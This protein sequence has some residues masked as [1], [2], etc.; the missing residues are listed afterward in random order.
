MK[1]RNLKWLFVFAL[2]L[3]TF[4]GVMAVPSMVWV[5]PPI[6]HGT[7]GV[8]D[9]SLVESVL[10]L[11]T[12]NPETQYSN[13]RDWVPCWG[14]NPWS[15]DGQW[16]VYQSGVGDN[17]GGGGNSKLNEICIIR[18]DGSGYKRLTYNMYCDTHGNFT[19]DGKKIVFQRNEGENAAIWIM[20]SDGS[21]QKS[22]TEEHGTIGDSCS[23]DCGE[24]KP[25]VSPDG[26]KIAFRHGSAIYVMNIDGSNPVKVSANLNGPT[27]HSWA[28]DSVWVLFNASK[29][30]SEDE[31]G[32]NIFKVRY[33]GKDLTQLTD[34]GEDFCNNWAAWSPDGKWI[35]YHHGYNSRVYEGPRDKNSLWI[36]QADGSGKRLLV[37]GLNDAV[38]EE[39]EWVCGPHSWHPSA[40]WIVF[41][42]YEDCSNSSL[43]AINIATKNIYRLTEGYGDGRMW[44]SPKGSH[45]LFKEYNTSCGKSRDGKLGINDND[46]DL[47]VLNMDSRFDFKGS[48]TVDTGSIIDD[49]FYANEGVSEESHT[50]KS[51]N[52]YCFIATAAFG[53]PLAKQ[54]QILRNFRD[55]YLLTN[56]AGQKF[57]AWY[58]QNGPVAAAWI[59]DKPLAKAAVQVALYPLIGFSFLL[60]SGYMPAA[61]LGFLLTA[62]FF[63]RFRENKFRAT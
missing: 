44:W 49:Y 42:R 3:L 22:L 20:N 45:I 7:L 1:K 24:Q 39:D 9:K 30:A 59:K 46:Y 29:C 18:P 21:N 25:M 33:N 35:S 26:T 38:D 56:A 17:K 13:V 5:E 58:Y 34:D 57:V 31:C 12:G 47:L 50:K 8:A 55:R 4:T 51:G 54:V 27:K 61:A 52:D 28:P 32:Q 41:K 63:V 43:Y 2:V 19:P 10:Q 60:L 40:Q 15:K 6:D 23:E 53:S 48:V 37:E 62:F 11:T 14:V 36:M 16:I